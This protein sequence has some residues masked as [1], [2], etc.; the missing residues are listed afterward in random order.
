ML[1]ST[2]FILWS[3]AGLAL[4]R[5]IGSCAFGVINLCHI[6]MEGKMKMLNGGGSSKGST[7][8]KSVVSGMSG[9]TGLSGWTS[10]AGSWISSK[11]SSITPSSIGSSIGR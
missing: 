9:K 7:G 11:M 2:R 4:F 3:V 1:T 8:T 10:G 5:A 6:I